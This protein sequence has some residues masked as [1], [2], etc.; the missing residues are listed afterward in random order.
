M[1]DVM[2][3][4]DGQ[5]KGTTHRIGPVT[6]VD[7]PDRAMAIARLKARARG[8]GA[9]ALMNLSLCR[10]VADPYF[11]ITSVYGHATAVRV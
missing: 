2:I 11:N 6:V 9:N 4:P 5:Y 8:M 7:A 3:L 10:T 1:Q